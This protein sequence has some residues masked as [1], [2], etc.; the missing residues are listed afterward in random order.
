MHLQNIPSI[1]RQYDH[2]Y[3]SPHF[4]DTA[5]SCSGQILKQ[6]DQGESVLIVTVFSA[7]T[8]HES[9]IAGNALKSILDYKQRRK[10]DSTAMKRLGV[11]YLWLDYPE[12][13]FRDQPPWARYWP[14]Y[15]STP[16]NKIL[17]DQLT[18]ELQ[19]ICI[20]TNCADLILP[21]GVGQ[22][23]DHQ[24]LFQAGITRQ[25]KNQGSCRTRFYE[26]IPYALFSFL[27]DYRLNK[28]GIKHPLSPGQ[29]CQTADTTR[30]SL[31][32]TFRLASGIPY[33]GTHGALVK[34]GLFLFVMMFHFYTRYLMRSASGV[35]YN[36]GLFP[37]VCDIT[38]F[39]DRK[40]FAISAY[41]SQLSGPMLSE[42]RIKMG[43]AAYGRTLGM[44]GGSF[45][46]RYWTMPDPN[47]S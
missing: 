10:E 5:A 29:R 47:I 25:M 27:L 23:M 31:K 28:I 15:H 34:P 7:A 37:E 42:H 9:A 43:L 16:N 32:E 4:D 41:R 26:E 21:L 35:S 11:D 45:G 12:F 39:I 22:H 1:H 40:I 13:L 20:R 38:P 18:R 3:I 36:P 2:V 6:L 33:L 44:P 19:D 14:H 46:E 8:A 30:L 24:V 17:C